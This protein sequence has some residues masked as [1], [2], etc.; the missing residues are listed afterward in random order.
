METIEESATGTGPPAASA[1]GHRLRALGLHAPDPHPGPQR[2]Q[3]RRDTGDQPAAA[4]ADQHVGQLA[5]ASVGELQT[6]GAL[7]GDHHRVVE[8]VDQRQALVPQPVG[9]R[10]RPAHAVG[11]PQRGAR[12]LDAVSTARAGADRGI[13]TVAFTSSAAATSPPARCRGC[14]R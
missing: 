6:D 3:R 14:R 7:T 13:T 8:G 9:Q 11:Q 5:G 10:E 12:R 2:P 4:D 1:C